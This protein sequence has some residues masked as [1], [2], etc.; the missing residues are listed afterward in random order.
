MSIANRGEVWIADLGYVAKTRPCLVLSV[1]YGDADR[2]V[3]TLVAHTTSVRGSDFEVVVTSPF[4]KAGA[5]DAQNLLTV[6]VTKLLKRM[7]TLSA[8]ELQQVERAVKDWLG[9]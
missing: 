5:F 7:G 3:V 9:L 2:A 1:P 4:L 8:A 6:P